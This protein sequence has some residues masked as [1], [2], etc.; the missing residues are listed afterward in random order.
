M[1]QLQ[2]Y[3]GIA[4]AVGSTAWVLLNR[5]KRIASFDAQWHGLRAGELATQ[6][7]LRVERGAAD[8]NFGVPL[9]ARDF[10]DA[11]ISDHVQVDVLLAGQRA[12][13][14]LSL[15]YGL[16][17]ESAGVRR[18][19]TGRKVGVGLRTRWFDCRLAVRAAQAFP[20]FE[21]LSRQS[22]LGTIDR[23]LG[24]PEATTGVA[25]VDSRFAVFTGEP[26]MAQYLGELLPRFSDFETC[27][28]H[29]IGDGVSIAFAMQ[30]RRDPLVASVLMRATDLADKLVVV[31]RAVGG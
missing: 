13:L 19:I 26:R 2:N 31:A 4:V 12:G 5:R 28:V 21:V 27:G 11:L 24:L 6:L 15:H 23:L 10:E 29:L 14:P 30:D 7:G 9:A 17:E 18:S 3:V 25:D 1:E 16:R 20:P 8:F 22:P